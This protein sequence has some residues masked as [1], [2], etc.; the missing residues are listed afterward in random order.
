MA[1]ARRYV[2]LDL[3]ELER[4][5]GLTELM[6]LLPMGLFALDREGRIM[7]ANSWLRLQFGVRPGDHISSA[8]SPAQAARV[9]TWHAKLGYG[10]DVSSPLML[11]L[12]DRGLGEELLLEAFSGTIAGRQVTVG[13][14]LQQTN[15][16]LRRSLS[17]LLT[18][19]RDAV[20]AVEDVLGEHEEPS[21]Q[22][23]PSPSTWQI[24]QSRREAQVSPR[25]REVLDLCL[26]GK[27]I[28]GIA[29][30]LG[31]SVFT[32]RNHLKNIYRKLDVT[33]RADLVRRSQ[34]HA[35]P[36]TPQGSVADHGPSGE[37]RRY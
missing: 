28:Q 24:D 23:P 26:K 20:T 33:S 12:C 11:L 5:G 16:Y 36:A 37:Y 13:L 4:T 2:S 34:G 27:K 10:A 17:E 8:L 15:A 3:A 14:V 32:V 7:Y 6:D 19:L 30:Q 31:I 1:G 35:A 18:P 25:E 21:S 29:E 22:P 9:E